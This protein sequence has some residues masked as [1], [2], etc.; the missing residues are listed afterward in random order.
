MWAKMGWE[1]ILSALRLAAGE[2]VEELA[3]KY[4]AKYAEPPPSHTYTFAYD[5]TNLLLKAIEQVAVADEDGTLHIGR[6]ALRDALYASTLEGVVG[7][8]DCDQFG[9]CN[10]PAFNIVQLD[11][12]VASVEDLRANVVFTSK[13][14]Q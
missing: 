2:A 7:T 10:A 12:S 9:D 1:C 8:L 6:Q 13:P 11:D 14:E 4:E 5:A 3:Q